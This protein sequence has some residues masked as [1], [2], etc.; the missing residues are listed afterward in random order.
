M[1]HTINIVSYR[2]FT[3]KLLYLSFMN[4]YSIF[5]YIGQK[6]FYI[7]INTSD[8]LWLKTSSQQSTMS[9]TKLTLYWSSLFW[10]FSNGYQFSPGGFEKRERLLRLRWT[11]LSVFHHGLKF[12]LLGLLGLLYGFAM[13]IF[14]CIGLLNGF[15]MS[16][17][18]CIELVYGFTTS[19]LVWPRRLVFN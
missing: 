19:S 1:L 15:A 8:L 6:Y 13:S 3:L 5:G 17:L 11:K 18:I 12:I 7:H 16:I 14:V 10:W 4:F 2:W 9:S